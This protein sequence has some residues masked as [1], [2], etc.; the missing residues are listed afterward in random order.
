MAKSVC[1]PALL[2]VGATCLLSIT[3]AQPASTNGGQR[4]LARTF[5]EDFSELEG[6]PLIEYK[7]AEEPVDQEIQILVPE[8]LVNLFN[9]IND[10]LTP[11][12][13]RPL[14]ATAVQVYVLGLLIFGIFYSFYML[15]LPIV[16]EPPERDDEEVED[17]ENEDEED[18]EGYGY[19]NNDEVEEGT[20]ETEYTQEEENLEE[21]EYGASQEQEGA[22]DRQYLGYTQ[23]IGE[24]SRPS[25]HMDRVDSFWADRS[26][27][28]TPLMHRLIRRELQLSY[29]AP[30]S[31]QPRK[32]T[33]K[34][35]LR[36]VARHRQANKKL[37]PE[38]KHVPLRH[39]DDVNRI[40][41]Y[42]EYDPVVELPEPTTLPWI[43]LATLGT[44]IAGFNV[45]FGQML[46]D[47]NVRPNLPFP[48]GLN[49]FG[50]D[51]SRQTQLRN[52]SIDAFETMSN[53]PEPSCNPQMLCETRQLMTYVP[54]FE[55]IIQTYGLSLN[56]LASDYKM[57]LENGAAR[58]SCRAG[59]PLCTPSFVTWLLE[60]AKAIDRLWPIDD[61]GSPDFETGEEDQVQPE[62]TIKEKGEN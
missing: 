6:A 23:Y 52:D 49:R 26:R 24:P 30:D 29:I 54:S 58:Q 5:D 45:I 13:P 35:A 25:D 62:E 51:L 8:V 16:Y 1:M 39:P 43:Q 11:S 14:V 34:K 28:T 53:L 17:E 19:N 38:K 27:V 44:L 59:Q 55:R 21:E 47:I 9:T 20:A 22:E 50:R 37:Y 61:D 2:L 15:V 7:Q 48:I 46:L 57:A 3:A 12:L 18:D 31:R 36:G 10:Y 32:K 33:H 4:A 40:F 60:A 41:V 56:G 42:D